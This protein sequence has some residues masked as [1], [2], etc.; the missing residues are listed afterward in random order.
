[1]VKSK[2]SNRK[3]KKRKLQVLIVYF[4]KFECLYN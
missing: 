1:M 2:C 4:F 3:D